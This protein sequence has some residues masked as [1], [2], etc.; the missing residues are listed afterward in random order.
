VKLTRLLRILFSVVVVT[1]SP[2]H[3]LSGGIQGALLSRENPGQGALWGAVGAAGSEVAMETLYDAE[4]GS[5]AIIDG[6][7]KRITQGELK[8]M[9]GSVGVD[10]SQEGKARENVLAS[11]AEPLGETRSRDQG[12]KESEI[13]PRLLGSMGAGQGSLKLGE[14]LTSEQRKQVISGLEQV[15]TK[16]L[17]ADVER[18]R[19]LVRLG[20]SG[21]ALAAGV[22]GGQMQIM[23]DM[24]DQ[25]LTHNYIQAAIPAGLAALEAAM[26]ALLAAGAL[27]VTYAWDAVTG[28]FSGESEQQLPFNTTDDKLPIKGKSGDNTVGGDKSASKEKSKVE[29]KKEGEKS[30]NSGNKKESKGRKQDRKNLQKDP[31]Q[32]PKRH[33]PTPY[34]KKTNRNAKT[35][36]DP[37]V[38]KETK[39]ISKRIETHEK[40]LGPRDDKQKHETTLKAAEIEGKGGQ[41]DL[42][43]QRGRTYD[44]GNKVQETQRGMRNDIDQMQ[45]KLGDPKLPDSERSVL[46][47]MIS[48]TSK[49]RDYTKK[50]VKPRT[51]AEEQARSAQDRLIRKKHFSSESNLHF[52]N[53]E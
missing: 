19:N 45:R 25:A 15:F 47:K 8:E 38:S 23:D 39:E 30:G 27:G 35:Q 28:L 29:E 11:K 6:M 36:N 4:I 26:P 5:R 9:L 31:E 46:Q 18:S 51:K 16:E 21:V 7:E 3:A 40:N 43:K 50:F 10:L 37:N 22:D 53:G 49:M 17:R 24:A 44:H 1:F 33:F 34:F 2:L 52:E 12:G 14:A 41:I 32:D 13:L 20:M 48:R 42:A